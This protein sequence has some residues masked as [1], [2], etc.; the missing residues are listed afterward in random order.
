MLL[1]ILIIYYLD[2]A[3]HI[4]Q[5]ITK[6]PKHICTAVLWYMAVQMVNHNTTLRKA[7]KNQTDF[8]YSIIDLVREI[9]YNKNAKYIVNE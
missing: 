7:F 8:Y 9:E 5:T 6:E 1:E 2:M 3:K 4:A